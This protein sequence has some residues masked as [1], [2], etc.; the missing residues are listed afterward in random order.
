M[1]NASILG[2]YGLTAE[3][4]AGDPT[5]TYPLTQRWAERLYEAGFAGVHYAARHDPRLGSRSVALF[6][7][8]S[9]ASAEISTTEEWQHDNLTTTEPIGPDLIDELVDQYGL[10]VVGDGSPL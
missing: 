2:S 4:S 3:V 10:T 8:H 5:S 9:E 7:K 6:G 1:T